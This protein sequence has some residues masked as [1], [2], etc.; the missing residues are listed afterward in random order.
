[1]VYRQSVITCICLSFQRCVAI[2]FQTIYSLSFRNN[3]YFLQVFLC[4]SNKKK[5]ETYSTLIFYSQHLRYSDLREDVC[6]NA[7]VTKEYLDVCQ[8]KLSRLKGFPLWRERLWVTLDDPMY[9]LTARVSSSCLFLAALGKADS[10][11]V[12]GPYLTAMDVENLDQLIQCPQ[13]ERI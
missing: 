10:T 1:M 12:G 13:K 11:V 8:V 9:S 4:A 6:K 2:F 5:L 3:F 7:Q